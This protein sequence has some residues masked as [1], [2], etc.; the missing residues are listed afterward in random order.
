MFRRFWI[1]VFALLAAP[2]LMHADTA[3]PAGPT[4]TA[5]H[6]TVQLVVPP[7]QI[8]PGQNFKA[9][10]YFKL[11]PGW[12]VYWINAGDSGEPPSMKWALPDGIKAD[13]FEFPA[14]KRLPLGPL[15]DYG[16]EGE[17]LFPIP[18]HVAQDFKADGGKVT[19]GGKATWLVCREVCIP[20]HAQLAVERPFG[21]AAN[22]EVAADAALLK[23]G[24][25]KLPQP[26]PSGDAAKFRASGDG[27]TL[28]VET[29]S[30]EKSA[31]FFPFEQNV[32]SNPAPQ[33]AKATGKGVELSLTKDSTLTT[34][35]KE[36]HGLLVLG[37]GRAYE[38]HATPGAI[39]SA[40]VGIAPSSGEIIRTALL[41]MIGGMI[42]NLMPCVFPVLFIKGLALVQSSGEERH[43][44]RL[45]GLVYTVGIL[46]SFWLLV[47]VLLG[48]R[49][50]GHNLG[51]GFQFQS[52]IFVAMMALLLFFLG[53]SLA[54]QF[55]IGLSMTSA[56][57]SLANK[58]GYTGSFFTGVLAVVVATPCAAPFM[59]AAIG[60]ALSSSAIITFVIFTA[61]ALGLAIPYLLLAFNPSWT[62]LL[63]RPGAW[64]EVLKQAVSVPIFGTVIWLIWVYTQLVGVNALLA[65]LAAFLL[66]AI[67]GWIMGRWPAK[68]PATIAAAIVLIL[69]I[70]LPVE[71]ART[72][73]APSAKTGGAAATGWEPFTPD[74]V[75]R[76]R[77]QG[78]PVFVDFTA[79]WCLSC[80][81]NE[82]VVLD[83]A[84]VQNK[85][86]NSGV[87]LIRADWT[88]HDETI[89]NTLASL[90]R[91]SVP[92]YVIYP[93]DPQ[94]QPKVLPEVLTP[95]IVFDALDSVKPQSKTG[96]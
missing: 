6:L 1:F 4:A 86:K 62:R 69:A 30:S 13:A 21:A 46:A 58:S 9:G 33:T 11:D 94:A 12:H 42:L 41:A 8:Y 52:P 73:S 40:A 47:G 71:A 87:V 34:A 26:L 60:Y 90:G 88:S 15:M 25:G 53:L 49:G 44:M 31:A 84:E 85:L 57:S 20:G 7:T 78:K 83:K 2:L 28:A 10:L 72:L 64:M 93:A 51:W 14:P 82:R 89:A 29:G 45:H 59:G 43:K 5:S 23:Q 27:F 50:A 17:V 3:A 76:Y 91:N 96:E 74:A 65:L 67:A 77:A 95:G 63:P 55:E 79:S 38:V 80:Q 81:V 68:A 32:L 16:Y 48:L 61:L 92:T 18:M 22:G 19:L 70:A 24:E 35:P 75:A 56:G 36:L 37:D 54:G 39:N 66:L